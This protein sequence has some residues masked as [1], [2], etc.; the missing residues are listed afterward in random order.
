MTDY[1]RFNIYEDDN[2]QT[3][4]LFR[5]R[6]I[7]KNENE[8]K[9]IIELSSIIEIVPV[10]ENKK[11]FSIKY[12]SNGIKN[13]DIYSSD[14]RDELLSKII[15]MKD[16][17][18]KIISDYSIETFKCYNLIMLNSELLKEIGKKL[19]EVNKGK[20]KKKSLSNSKFVQYIAFCTLYR[21]YS[22]INKLSSQELKIYYNNLSKIIKMQI[23][24]DI[25]GLIFEDKNQIRIAIIPFNQKDV[26]TIKNLI[27]SYASKYLSYE[28]K[29]EESDDYLKGISSVPS[30]LTMSK[31]KSTMFKKNKVLGGKNPG[32]N[33]PTTNTN[34]DLN[35]KM[36]NQDLRLKKN[37]S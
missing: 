17:S 24:S 7:I 1:Q 3:L 2:L 32:V 18:S 9:L 13:V 6:I 25:Y 4:D 12:Y 31:A 23:V 16:R 10:K 35:I 27:I 20:E 21:T 30:H 15:T 34:N 37:F 36:L 14:D 8:N 19:Y 5:N 33:Q 28:I 26:L 22:V 29:Y 11:E